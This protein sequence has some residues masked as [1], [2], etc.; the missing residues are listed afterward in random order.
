[1]PLL[2]DGSRRVSI[3]NEK[4]SRLLSVDV[5]SASG[6]TTKGVVRRMPFSTLL[7]VSEMPALVKRRAINCD[8][9]KI[10]APSVG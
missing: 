5:E 7:H 1:M 8:L 10:S 4:S 2:A 3:A 6:A 9:P